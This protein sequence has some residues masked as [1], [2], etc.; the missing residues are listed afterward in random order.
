VEHIRG[1]GLEGMDENVQGPVVG[2]DSEEQDE[3]EE[4]ISTRRDLETMRRAEQMGFGELVRR[5]EG[6]LGVKVGKTPYAAMQ[7]PERAVVPGSQ[8]SLDQELWAASLCGNHSRVAEVLHLGA[9]VH[10][11]DASRKDWTPM[12]YAATGA[13]PI[14]VGCSDAK[15]VCRR[16]RQGC[17]P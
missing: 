5:L 6:A 15:Q 8:E 14:L 1:G 13:D 12:H 3:G 17:W 9:D 4:M 16:P 7:W 2:R 10:A 11:A